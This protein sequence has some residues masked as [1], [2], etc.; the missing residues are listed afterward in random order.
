MRVR[1]DKFWVM[2]VNSVQLSLNLNK[3]RSIVV[4]EMAEKSNDY[5]NFVEFIFPENI[6]VAESEERFEVLSRQLLEKGYADFSGEN[7][8]MYIG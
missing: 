7:I 1:V 2:E 5:D 6:S 8:E 3:D 4:F